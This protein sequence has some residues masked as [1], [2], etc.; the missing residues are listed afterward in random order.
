MQTDLL[1]NEE[2]KTNTEKIIT[3][4]QKPSSAS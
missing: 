1:K 4:I 3:H 2:E